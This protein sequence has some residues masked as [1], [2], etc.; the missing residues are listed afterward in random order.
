VKRTTLIALALTLVAGYLY[1][2][3]IPREALFNRGQA[4]TQTPADVGLQWEDVELTTA[5]DGLKLAAWWM[6][7]QNPKAALIFVHGGGSNRHSEFFSALS[8]YRD[9][10]ARDVSVLALELRNHGASQDD[11]RGLQFGL[12][13]QA[14]AAAA[15]TWVRA[16]APHLPLFAM[17]ISMGGATVI[18]AAHRGSGL[19]GLILLDPLLDTRSTFSHGAWTASGLPAFVFLPAAW[20]AQQFYGLPSGEL[21]AL[22]VAGQL[23]LPTLLIQDPEDPVTRAPFARLLAERNPQVELW[24]APSAN[25]FASDL[26]WKG[27]WGSHVAAYSLFPEKTLAQIDTFI[28]TQGQATAP[29]RDV[30]NQLAN[31]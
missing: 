12:T 10:V 23:T 7:A 4:T 20:V 22:H 11:G 1:G 26:A 16:K 28:T 14:D 19:T 24:E 17:G 15:T 6:P 3:H 18:H 27:R 30:L 25:A 5:T 29:Y 21:E 9:M 13:E 8:F 31:P 2:V